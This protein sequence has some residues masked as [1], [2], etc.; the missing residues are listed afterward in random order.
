[1]ENTQ[2]KRDSGLGLTRALAITVA[3][4]LLAGFWWGW[5]LM[6]QRQV[7]A[8]TVENGYQRAFYDYL[9]QVEQIELTAGKLQACADLQAAL[10]LTDL[11]A[12]ATTAAN[13]AAALPLPQ[14]DLALHSGWLHGVSALAEAKTELLLRGGTLAASD[15][16]QLLAVYEEAQ[17]LYA[18]L[19][20][21][22]Q[23]LAD[24]TSLADYALPQRGLS[25][26]Q[27]VAA[28]AET[29]VITAQL[30]QLRGL[31]A[32][33]A[34]AAAVE[35]RGLAGRESISLDAAEQAAFGYL[36]QLGYTDLQLEEG[37]TVEAAIPAYLFRYGSGD[38]EE[39]GQTINVTVS[40]AGGVL[41]ALYGGQAPPEEAQLL[42]RADAEAQALQYAAQLGYGGMRLTEE[43]LLD[44]ALLVELAAVVEGVVCYPDALQLL[45]SLHDGTLLALDAGEYWLHHGERDLTMALSAAASEEHLAAGLVSS[46]GVAAV[47]ADGKGG[48]VLCWEH[49]CRVG[50]EEYWAYLH[51]DAGSEEQVLRCTRLESGEFYCR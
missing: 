49:A 9:E 29:D 37:C 15:R 31:L 20:E 26:V 45:V 5:E 41:L 6:Q 2:D 8:Q 27:A 4:A 51:G 34:E 24:G 35:V 44:G 16:E 3:L 19:L 40:Q 47:I 10:L 28:D 22:E 50:E 42:S 18:A 25:A 32:D 39:I 13:A 14:Q 46:G 43:R 17:L 1:M 38:E 23:A 11:A 30:L 12:A 36:Q 21:M 7:L 48:E 33:E